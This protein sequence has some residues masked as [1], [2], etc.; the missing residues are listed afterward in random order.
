MWQFVCVCLLL[1]LSLSLWLIL[2]CLQTW[3][4]G[5]LYD[6]EIEEINR[7]N[8]TAAITFSG[9]GNAEVIP[10]QNLKPL[11]EGKHSK[12]DGSAKTKSKYELH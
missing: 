9:Y 8:R 7:E 11:E 5:R 10:L 12:E 6:A 3:F 2:T 1:N 4:F